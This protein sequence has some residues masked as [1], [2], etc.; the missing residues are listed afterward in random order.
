MNGATWARARGWA[1]WKALITLVEAV[2]TG[3]RDEPGIGFPARRDAIPHL[4]RSSH[5]RS[6]RADRAHLPGSLDQPDQASV[7]PDE[8]DTIQ[9]AG[10]RQ[11]V[12]AVRT[13][14]THA[15]RASR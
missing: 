15:P 5:L 11:S 10:K 13:T 1:L 14:R 9:R 2:S 8:T 3:R 7:I 6:A 4:R 12:P